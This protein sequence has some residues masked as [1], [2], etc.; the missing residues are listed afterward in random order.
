MGALTPL[1]PPG[2]VAS[3][4][5]AVRDDGPKEAESSHRSTLCAAYETQERDT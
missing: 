5:R 1:L 4:V 3:W 2:W